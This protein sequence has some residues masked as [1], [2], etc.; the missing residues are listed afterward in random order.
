MSVWN[1]V[2]MNAGA[3]DATLREK[4]LVL[5]MTQQEVADRAKISLSSYQ[6]FESG[7]RNIRTASFEVACRV[8]MAL[9]MDPTAFYEGKYVF[10]EPTIFDKDGR[11]YV[12]TGRLVDEEVDETEAINAM[13]IHVYGNGVYIP[14]RILRAMGSPQYVQIMVKEDERM[15]G[16]KIIKKA[17]E[18]TFR[19]TSDAYCG[20]WRGVC[21]SDDGLMSLVYKYMRKQA[22]NYTGEP[23]LFEKGCLLN[24]GRMETSEYK[25]PV[26]NYYQLEL[27]KAVAEVEEHE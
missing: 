17:E 18:N 12:Q 22:G 2:H 1:T 24:L 15:I 13:R 8:I 27:K 9:D 25:V 6:K 21:L 20:R 3:H 7:D 5:E 10:D 26:E 14:M 23:E 4:R 11:K 16:L 19:I